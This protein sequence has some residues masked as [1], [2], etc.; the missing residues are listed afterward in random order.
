MTVTVKTT[1][2]KT[3]TLNPKDIDLREHYQPYKFVH[4]GRFH[5]KRKWWKFWTRE[6]YGVAEVVRTSNP[7]PAKGTR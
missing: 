2:G 1:S 5:V 4:A 3:I 6:Y 7:T